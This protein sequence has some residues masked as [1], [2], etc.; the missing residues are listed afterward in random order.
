[1]SEEGSEVTVIPDSFVVFA[2]FTII[3]IVTFIT[4]LLKT[5]Q[6]RL[7][8]KLYT[9]LAGVY[10]ILLLTLVVMKYVDPNDT[11]LLFILDAMTN[12]T[13][14][15]TPLMY[16]CIS[17]AFLNDWEKLPKRIW[18]LFGIAF[19]NLLVVWTNPIHHLQYK[20]FSVVRSEIVFGPY[21]YIS[22]GFSYICLITSLA[23][24]LN[25]AWKNRS[26]IYV[27][28]CMLFALGGA[29]PLVVSSISTLTPNLSI[30]ATPVSFVGTIITNGIVIYK[31]HMLDIKPMATQLVMDSISD[32]YLI[33][34]DTGLVISYNKPFADMF[35]TRYGLK[36]G[37]HLKD[38]RKE[39]D[40]A[41][42]A[43][44]YN[45]L[46]A[47]D[48]CRESLSVIS[49]EQALLT[50]S[51]KGNVKNYY[52]TE[53]SPVLFSDRFAGFVIIY[54]DVTQLK[55]SMQEL[56][57]NQARMM[58]Q[59][60]LAFLGQMMGGL[61]HNLKTPIMSI[62]GCISS[63]YA[64]VDECR[65]SLDDPEVVR[66]DYLEIY[67]ELEGWFQKMQ[68]A[69]AYMSDI[70]SA[71]KGQATTVVNPADTVFT[72]DELFKRVT[73]LM[74]HE[75]YSNHNQLRI[76]Y[77]NQRDTG[78]K[79]DIN[80]LIQVLD[81]FISNAIQAQYTP[82][83]ITLCVDREQ[84]DLRIYV[85]DRG[86]G[87]SPRVRDHLFREMVTSKGIHGT[88]LGL[89]ISQAVV[90]G[91]FGGFLWCQDNPGGGAIFG[92]TIPAERITTGN[93]TDAGGEAR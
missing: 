38:F 21:M 74:R 4:W 18:I 11:A 39:D 8:H 83:E 53:V 78:I 9:A 79:G 90:H 28:Q 19:F 76:E 48:S 52:I 50:R 31:L 14:S 64:L 46:S 92:M 66:E 24:M 40:N 57:D 25:F 68:E 15:M 13:G 2:F 33:L 63:A 47:V 35:A 65:E 20:H 61:A 72:V 81:N 17:L 71:I 30:V 37:A 51:E 91:N 5:Q 42:D 44:I 3:L 60:R 45:L 75:L 58:E 93:S 6:V 16:L 85:K 27:R 43:V 87:I 36:E 70:I 54:K 86:S 1:M 62:S 23:L 73:L 12:T 89:Y 56:Q 55:A 34:S 80:S 77:N 32:A 82:G 26:K 10:V 69:S 59:E 22:G 7:L 41:A 67:S 84:E 49:Y 29:I 88:G